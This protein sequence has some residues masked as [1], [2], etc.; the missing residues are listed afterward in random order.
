[1]TYDYDEASKVYFTWR[2]ESKTYE[3]VFDRAPF[4]S[5]VDMPFEDTTIKVPVDYDRYLTADFG[6]YMQLPPEEK[7]S[8][9]HGTCICDLD[10]PA[11]YYAEQKKKK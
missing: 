1:M 10:R 5:T 3:T 11:A 8:G 9:G 6:D 7:R 4:S 2:V